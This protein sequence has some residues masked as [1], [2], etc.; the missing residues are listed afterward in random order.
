MAKR[1]EEAEKC[2]RQALALN[3][4]DATTYNNLGSL[5]AQQ[6]EGKKALTCY[7]KAI[8]VEPRMTGVYRNLGRLW[9]QLGD[10]YRAEEAWFR[11]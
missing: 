9:T 10:S 11:A 1:L 3:P 7:G 8:E 2:Y 4:N 5:Y 6:Q